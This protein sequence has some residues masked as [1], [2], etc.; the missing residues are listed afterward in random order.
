MPQSTNIQPETSQ[1]MMVKEGHASRIIA[2]Y[3]KR[4]DCKISCVPMTEGDI[5]TI[6]AKTFHCIQKTPLVVSPEKERQDITEQHLYWKPV[7]AY[8][9]K[10]IIVTKTRHKDFTA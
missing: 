3:Y 7:N 10:Y 5:R 9:I 8:V 1:V 6:D 4:I 2:L